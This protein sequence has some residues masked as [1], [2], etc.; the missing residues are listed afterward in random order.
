M[1]GQACVLYGGAEFSRD[2]DLVLLGDEANL[3][4]L[5]AALA[6]LQ[7]ETIAVP[8]FE[9]RFLDEGLAAHFRCHHPEAAGMRV[10]VMTRLRG[11][12]EFA[13]LWSRRVTMDFDGEPIDVLCLPDLVRAK[14][15]QRDKDWS[16]IRRLLEANYYGQGAGAT[17]QHILFW[18]R[19]LRTPE[20]LVQLA[21][22]Y[23]TACRQLL[24]ERPLLSAALDG[25]E[26]RLA[27]LLREEEDAERAADRAHW[28][29]LKARLEEL[30]GNRP[31]G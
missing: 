17:P 27:I 14:K 24:D 28:A 22:T 13:E 11:V 29:P 18:L 15:T 31:R 4:R 21:Q 7:A 16:M 10:D 26:S 19:E 30:R 23:G 1:G 20:L 5:R 12:P 3:L 25:N 6:E 8:P 2:T 9:K